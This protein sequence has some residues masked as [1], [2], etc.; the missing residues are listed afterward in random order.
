MLSDDLIQIKRNSRNNNADFYTNLNGL[1][2]ASLHNYQC[3]FCVVNW[4][5][6]FTG[7]EV[8]ASE[9]VGNWNGNSI[10]G[11]QSLDHK[12]TSNTT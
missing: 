6:L 7:N 12:L 9:D 3:E 8:I 11:K 10:S 4:K 2:K 5:I 1:K